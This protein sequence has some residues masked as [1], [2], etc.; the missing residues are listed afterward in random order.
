MVLEEL[1]K[2]AFGQIAL[3]AGQYCEITSMLEDA[4]NITQWVLNGPPPPKVPEPGD[5][6]TKRYSDGYLASGIH[7]LPDLSPAQQAAAEAALASA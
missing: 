2:W 7:P 5:F 4:E 1:R 3:R 6:V